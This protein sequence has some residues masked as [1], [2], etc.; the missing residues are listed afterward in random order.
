MTDF[1]IYPAVDLKD[2]NCVRLIHGKENNMTI[3]EID[4]INQVKFFLENGFKWVHVVDLNAAFG[5]NDNKKIILQILKIFKKNVKIQLGGGIRSIEDIKFWIDAGVSRIVLGTFA[6]KN[7]DLINNLSNF[8][9]KKLALG[10]DI[11]NKKI[12]VNGWTKLLEVDPI[13]Y[14]KQIDKKYFDKVIYTD[15]SKDGTLEG[16]NLSETKRFAK[17]IDIPIIASGGISDLNNVKALHDQKDIGISGVIIG[18]AIYEKKFDLD[19]LVKFSG[20]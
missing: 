4:P 8:F 7:P 15:I 9:C 1:Q 12:A 3:Y 20:N 11:K 2:G 17:S 10:L 18:K 6:F 19:N 13:E 14:V 16:V 5:K